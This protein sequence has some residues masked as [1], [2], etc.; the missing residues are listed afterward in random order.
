MARTGPSVK[1]T[2]REFS[3]LARLRGREGGR[4][5]V[6]R[7]GRWGA[8]AHRA[9]ASLGR[10][11]PCPARKALRFSPAPGRKREPIGRGDARPARADSWHA[12][13]ARIRGAVTV[14]GAI[15]IVAVV[16][17]PVPFGLARCWGTHALEREPSPGV[18]VERA[19]PESATQGPE[20]RQVPD[21]ACGSPA[22]GSGAT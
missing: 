9:H 4:A 10:R 19:A 20:T 22:V 1:V 12:F 14:S 7:R 2:A 21:S 6:I 3:S 5:G 15:A 13:S 18:G 16:F 17:V 8:R 11:V